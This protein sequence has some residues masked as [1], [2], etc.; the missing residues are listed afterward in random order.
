M[1]VYMILACA[2]LTATVE[3]ATPGTAAGEGATNAPL[4]SAVDTVAEL[5]REVSTMPPQS[6]ESALLDYEGRV[7]APRPPE[8]VTTNFAPVRIVY[9]DVPDGDFSVDDWAEELAANAEQGLHARNGHVL[10]LVRIQAL[11]GEHRQLTR[12]RAKFRAI[13]FLRHHYP[14]LPKEFSAQCRV[15]MCETSDSG[16]SCVAVVSFAAQDI[17]SPGAQGGTSSK[18]IGM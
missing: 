1:Q 2:A 4:P 9:P 16:E 6:C 13:E 12:L 14:D 18:S 17:L 11:V 7:V 10:V 8:P 15:L 3:C 5:G